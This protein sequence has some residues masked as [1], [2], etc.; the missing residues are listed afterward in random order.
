MTLEADQRFISPVN[1]SEHLARTL[2][3]DH[4]SESC[5]VE[6]VRACDLHDRGER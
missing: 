6:L 1:A 5:R 3:I 2:D 4:G